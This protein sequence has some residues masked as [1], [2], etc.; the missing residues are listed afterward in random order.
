MKRI[1]DT[2][3]R[4]PDTGYRKEGMRRRKFTA[5]DTDDSDGRDFG[6]V[7]AALWAA[8]GICRASVSDASS[9]SDGVSQP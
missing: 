3:Y 2:G 1:S 7:A 8:Q 9:G 6:A 4:I 5:D